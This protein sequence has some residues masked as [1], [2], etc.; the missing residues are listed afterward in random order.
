MSEKDQVLELQMIE[1]GVDEK[2]FPTTVT[3]TVTTVTGF[4]STVSNNNC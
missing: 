1:E 2:V 3:W 4:W